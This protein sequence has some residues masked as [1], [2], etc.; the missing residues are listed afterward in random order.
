MDSI[1]RNGVILA[2]VPDA[3]DLSA[4]KYIQVRTL[5]GRMLNDDQVVKLPFTTTDNLHQ[6]EWNLRSNSYKRL[7][8]VLKKIKPTTLLDIGCGNGWLIGRLA[9]EFSYCQLS[10][11]DVN[12][13]ELEQASQLFGSQ[14]SRFYYLD[15]INNS[16]FNT[17]SFEIIIF[18]ASIQYFDNLSTI[19]NIAKSLLKP[20]GMVLVNDSSFYKNDKESAEAKQRSEVYYERLGVPEMA[21]NYFHYSTP[22]LIGLGF[23]NYHSWTSMII[24]YPFPLFIYS[25]S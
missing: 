10:G 11:V 1:I 25:K 4:S 5:E 7:L 6:H 13:V 3:N 12:L 22:E 9:N 19:I 2:S 16:F 18:N 8:S 20:G 14:R 15:L 24:K 17:A 23:S 21:K